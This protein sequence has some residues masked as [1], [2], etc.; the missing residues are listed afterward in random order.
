MKINVDLAKSLQLTPVYRPYNQHHSI[1]YSL[2]CNANINHN[3]NLLWEEHPDYQTCPLLLTALGMQ[4]FSMHQT[5]GIECDINDILH[6]EQYIEVFEDLPESSELRQEVKIADVIDKKN[7]AIVI[8]NVTAYDNVTN[9][10]LAFMQFSLYQKNCGGFGG[11][12][13]SS[14][15]VPLERIPKHL[16]IDSIITVKNDVNQAALFRQCNADTFPLHIDPQ[17]AKEQGYKAP[18][19]HGLCTLGISV[20]AIV[21]RYLNGN[22]R[23]FKSMKCRFTAAVIPGQ[24][25]VIKVYKD[26][27]K[28]RFEAF[29]DNNVKV[30][31]SAYITLKEAFKL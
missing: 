13:H 21:N 24:T 6:H 11:P 3:L 28:L 30:I 15:E 9:K 18:I 20:Q 25:L 5:P 23:Q 26:G 29:V 27:N 4:S 7:A 16:Q 31:S 10:K 22:W 2:A 14:L 12:K 1:L 17:A 19:L 8:R